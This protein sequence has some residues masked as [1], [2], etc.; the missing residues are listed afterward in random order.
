MNLGELRKEINEIDRQLVELFSKRMAVSARI[1]EYKRECGMP[2][3]D[4]D[5]E[6]ELLALIA[7]LAGEEL[8]E[9]AVELYTKILALSREY[10]KRLISGGEEH[11]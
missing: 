8:A 1:A 5:R 11:K 2:V 6:R 7:D 9:Y 10:Q 3:Q 4:T